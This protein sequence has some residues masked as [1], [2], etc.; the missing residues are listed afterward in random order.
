MLGGSYSPLAPVGAVYNRAMGDSSASAGGNG[1]REEIAVGGFS[2]IVDPAAGGVGAAGGAEGGMPAWVPAGFPDPSGTAPGGIWTFQEPNAVVIVRDGR[3]LVAASPYTRQHDS[4]QILDNA[5][6][7]YFSTRT[8]EAPEGGKLRVDWEM[9]ARIV[10]GVPGDLYDG[11][12]SFHLLDM[13]T[14]TALDIFAAN[15]VVATVYAR[16][17]FP[18]A[19]V[20]RPE[21]GPRYFSVFDEKRDATE[22]GAWNRYAM[23]YDRASATVRYEMNGEEIGRYGDVLPVGPCL[24][25]MGLMTERD[26]D[27]VKGSTSLHGQG[28]A[29]GWGEIRITLESA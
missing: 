12:V 9:S 2:S 24:L 28:A 6:H 22:P 15:E 19:Q 10:D 1:K 21:A 5:K 26:L 13:T 11:F 18:G 29:G 8:F 17:P 3:L 7:M 14:G 25:A 27:P 23:E 4:V 20:P 16:L